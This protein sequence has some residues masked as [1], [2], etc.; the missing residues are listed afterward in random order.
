MR[1]ADRRRIEERPCPRHHSPGHQTGQ[2]H[3]DPR[4]TDQDHGFRSCAY[5]AREGEAD[6][7][8]RA[9]GDRGLH[10]TRADRRPAGGPPD[11]HLLARRRALRDVGR[12]SS[13]RG[14]LRSRHHVFDPTHGAPS[15][16]RGGE[17]NS[18]RGQRPCRAVSSQ[19]P[20][21]AIRG[22]RRVPGVSRGAAGG[23]ARRQSFHRR[24]R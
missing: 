18:G 7:D 10:V 17:W 5:P 21:G 14:R 19:V 6:P 23:E 22:L 13:L 16:G 11:G 3:G 15:A 4:R 1:T 2:H 24:G 9:S 20:G 8:R 12:A